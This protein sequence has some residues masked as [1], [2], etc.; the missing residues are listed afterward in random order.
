MKSIIGLKSILI[1]LTVIALMPHSVYGDPDIL[2]NCSTEQVL[3]V[4]VSYKGLKPHKPQI[5]K[6]KPYSTM[7]FNT[8]SNPSLPPSQ[9]N[10]R[11]LEILSIY[12]YGFSMGVSESEMK[13]EKSEKETLLSVQI[14]CYAIRPG[15][16][17]ATEHMIYATAKDEEEA[18]L[19]MPEWCEACE[20]QLKER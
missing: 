11:G 6:I 20:E 8:S 19:Y 4:K 7:M 3:R 10:V 12:Q 9:C 14:K 17:N 16:W 15:D 5:M 1:V 2:I 13:S 18:V